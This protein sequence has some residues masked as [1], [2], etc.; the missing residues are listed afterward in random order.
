MPIEQIDFE[1]WLAHPLTQA[2]MAKAKKSEQDAQIR[3]AKASWGVPISE[4][5]KLDV[6]QLA[7]LRGKA[8]IF[9][10]LARIQLKDLVKPEQKSNERHSGVSGE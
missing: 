7:Y 2:L 10:S 1:E 4:L 3:W 5:D 8:E 9:A 6:V